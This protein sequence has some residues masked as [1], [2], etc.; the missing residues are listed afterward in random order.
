MPT[1]DNTNVNQNP[2]ATDA[3]ADLTAMSAAEMAAGLS[4]GQLNL[5]QINWLF[6]QAFLSITSQETCITT[7][8]NTFNDPATAAAAGDLV[9]HTDLAGNITGY[10]IAP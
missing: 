4:C 2:F 1:C 9:A 7:L 6:G 8:F 10:M 5:G 3:A